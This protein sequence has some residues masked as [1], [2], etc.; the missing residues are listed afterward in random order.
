MAKKRKQKPKQKKATTPLDQPLLMGRVIRSVGSSHRVQTEAGQTVDCVVRGKFRIQEVNSTNPVAV[1]DLVGFLPPGE[2]EEMGVI[3]EIQPRKNYLLRKAIAHARK[4]HILAANVDQAIL[5]F[6]IT[7]PATSTGFA[8][9][10]LTVAEAYHIPVQVVINKVDL[11][12]SEE[13]RARLAEVKQIYTGIG[14]PVHEVN[15]L[16]EGYREAVQALL[17]D[18]ISFVGGHSGAG[19]STLINLIDSSLDLK[20]GDVSAYHQKGKHTTVYAEMFPLQGGGYIID[21]PGI[22][23]LGL[24]NFEKEELSHFFPEMR[25]RLPE[26]RFSNCLHRNEPGCAIKAALQTGG[27]HPSRYDSYLRML[28]EVEEGQG[29]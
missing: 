24:V 9:R 4:V 8:N 22:K 26:C 18:K 6:T 25:E 27:V 23:E 21:S 10:F 7:L 29:Y 19:K 1:G 17:R 15:A 28:E 20:T 14:Y 16:D 12:T 5:L 3:T 2:E 13:Q 11:V